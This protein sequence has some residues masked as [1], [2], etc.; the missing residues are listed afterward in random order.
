MVGQLL[1]TISCLSKIH[2]PGPGLP[3]APGQS[4][5]S[6]AAAA[7]PK[8]GTGLG[9]VPSVQPREAQGGTPRVVRPGLG[10]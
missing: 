5:I 1:S 2:A 8:E 9:R 3:R 7:R 4:G 6:A 10:P